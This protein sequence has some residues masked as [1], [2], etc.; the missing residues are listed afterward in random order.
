MPLR[1]PSLFL[2]VGAFRKLGSNGGGYFDH[3]H[4]EFNALDTA[5]LGGLGDIVAGRMTP[6]TTDSASEPP[7]EFLLGNTAHRSN[8]IFQLYG[9]PAYR[10]ERRKIDVRINEVVVSCG[11]P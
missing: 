6:F 9:I 10:P 7:P 3:F 5:K 2:T 8:P 4:I 1:P 11:Y